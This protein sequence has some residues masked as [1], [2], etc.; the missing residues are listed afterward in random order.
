MLLEVTI[1]VRGPAKS[2]HTAWVQAREAR[3]VVDQILAGGQRRSLVDRGC[4]R[5]DRRDHGKRRMPD[6]MVA[7]NECI[8]ELSPKSRHGI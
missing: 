5:H 1:Q 6:M 3:A 2:P 8:H 7:R 4:A